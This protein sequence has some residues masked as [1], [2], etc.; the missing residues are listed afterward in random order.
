M[1]F[2]EILKECK[3]SKYK[4]SKLSGVPYST[5][6][7][8]CL[9]KSTFNK[10]S[11]ETIVRISHVIKVPVEELVTGIVYPEVAEKPSKKTKE[12]STDKISKKDINISSDKK[13]KSNKNSI[14]GLENQNTSIKNTAYTELEKK[15]LMEKEAIAKKKEEAF[16]KYKESIESKI[17]ILGELDFLVTYIKNNEV[18]ILYNLNRKKESLYLLSLIDE[19]CIKYN[20]PKC[21]EYEYIRNEED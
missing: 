21:K 8:I 6:S 15:A 12:K 20:F 14:V 4:L 5:I 3:I 13:K 2:N 11:A 10:C 18:E 7:D 16:L 9:G 1:D 17:A 19:F